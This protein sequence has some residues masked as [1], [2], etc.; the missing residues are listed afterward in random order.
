VFDGDAMVD[1]LFRAN[2]EPVGPELLGRA[3]ELEVLSVLMPV[4]SATDLLGV[5]G[6]R[7]AGALLR[8][9]QVLP[10]ARA[11]REQIDWPHVR[12]AVGDDPFGE[13]FLLLV[14]RLGVAPP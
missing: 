3:E 5:E 10:A 7:A 13:A 11:L 6:P 8:L 1:V 9:R 2:N 4:L 14:E 12:Q